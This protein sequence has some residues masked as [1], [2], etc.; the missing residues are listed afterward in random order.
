M[1]LSSLVETKHHVEFTIPLVEKYRPKDIDDIIMDDFIQ[2][3]INQMV[4]VNDIPNLIFSGEPSVGKT[5]TALYLV[6]K[7]FDKENIIELNASDD[8]GLTM[9]TNTI[10]P[11]C[12]KKT[13]NKK[14]I[15]LD[16]ADSITNK[17]QQLLENVIDKYNDK[18]RFV[19]ICNEYHKIN[20]S[21]QSRCDLL[22][23][24]KLKVSKL[25]DRLKHICDL[26]KINY[27]NNGIRRLI[28]FSDDDIRQCLNNLECLKYTYNIVSIET[29]NNIIDVPKIEYIKKIFNKCNYYQAIDTIQDL[30]HKGYSSNDIMLIFMKYIQSDLCVEFD[31]EF[32]L[33][34]YKLMCKYYIQINN[35]NDNLLQLIAFI[36]EFYLKLKK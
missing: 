9:I 35:G 22:N 36:S 24:T 7:I 17:A 18:T 30:Y 27:D 13:D 11:F 3:K 8:R 15:V 20:P 29:V 14:V 4:K 25:M 2:I 26:E 34:T 10:I 33:N 12:S 1:S 23:F 19:F 5:T 32:K 28:F 31:T 6:R 21:V 16:E